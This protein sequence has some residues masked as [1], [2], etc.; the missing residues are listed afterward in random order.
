MP[1]PNTDWPTSVDSTEDRTD[2][3]DTVF[4][5]DYDYQDEQIRRIQLWIGAT[6]KLLGEDISGAGP[7]GAVSPEADGGTAFQIAARND[8]TSGKLLSVGD[9]FDNVFSEKFYVDYLGAVYTAGSKV[10]SEGAGE[11]AALTAKATPTISD[12]LI[13]EDAAAANAK[14][15]ITIGDLPGG[16]GTDAD[17]IHDN[18]AG[19]IALVTEKGT[20]VSGDLLLIEDSADSN[21]K[22][23]V[24]VGNLPGGSGTDND[25]VH[26]NVDGEINAILEK[27]SP[28][29][30]DLILIEDSDPFPTQWSKKKVQISSLSSTDA[31]AIHDNV[32]G[33]ISAVTSKASPTAA[34][35]LLIE[36]AADSDNKKSVTF[37]S[38]TVPRHSN[39]IIGNSAAGDTLADC[40][41]L[42]AGDGVLLK[43]TIEAA[44]AGDYVSVRAGTYNLASGPNAQI[45]IPA[46][47][48]VAGAGRGDGTIISTPTGTDGRAFDVDNFSTLSDMK[49]TIVAPTVTQTIASYI[50]VTGIR[51]HLFRLQF[52]FSGV[53]TAADTVI[54]GVIGVFGDDTE[55][56]NCFMDS[57]PDGTGTTPQ[58]YGLAVAQGYRA[59]AR[60]ILVSGGYD[61]VYVD[62]GGLWAEHLELLNYTHT[63][64][65]QKVWS[66]NGGESSISNSRLNGQVTAA[67]ANR[68]I[69]V[70]GVTAQ[71][72]L[73]GTI[74]NVHIDNDGNNPSNAEYG[75]ALTWCKGWRVCNNHIRNYGT[76]TPAEAIHLAANTG[77]NIVIGNDVNTVAGYGVEDLGDRNEVAHNV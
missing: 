43:S 7:S 27:V 45:S 33:E 75:I 64:I 54:K 41:V 9:D 73:P 53:W 17:A 12:I 35:Y 63:G 14:K 61:A 52:G 59:W 1:F 16:S 23:R 76:G 38:I 51:S 47:V 49:F 21:N 19:E 11:I 48:R 8:F 42:D 67:I 39:V 30:T 22:K 40:D 72:V 15:S 71:G 74:S 32:A 62:R 20:P 69:S 55:I 10:L 13:I 29:G 18:V 34:D 31:A 58:F 4:A 36:D 66:T 68:G 25:A 44:S 3:V 77:Y 28:V 50:I 57:V 24:Q 65:T 70:E 60:R 37:G 2:G 56:E 26:D 46:N 6:G 5:A